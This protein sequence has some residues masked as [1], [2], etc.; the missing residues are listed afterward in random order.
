MDFAM[1]FYS[2]WLH[3]CSPPVSPSVGPASGYQAERPLGFH[4]PALALTPSSAL[5]P[6]HSFNSLVSCT[7]PDQ[8]DEE[9]AGAPRSGL[10]AFEALPGRGH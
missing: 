9:G 7:A 6:C 8:R 10:R 1:E 2:R 4:P 5:D 3:I